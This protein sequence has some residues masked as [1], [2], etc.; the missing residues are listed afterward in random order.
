M[1]SRSCLFKGPNEFRSNEFTNSSLT[2]LVAMCKISWIVFVSCTGVQHVTMI[3]IKKMLAG[4]V[5][6]SN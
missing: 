6:G 3:R 1:V 2:P 5:I 4:I